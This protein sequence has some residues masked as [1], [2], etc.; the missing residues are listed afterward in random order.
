[1]KKMIRLNK[2][3]SERGIGSRRKCEQLIKEGKIAVDNRVVTSLSTKVD[4][5]THTISLKGKKIPPP[6]INRYFL[7]HK[8][9]GYITTMHD[10]SGRPTITQFFPAIKERLFPVGRL[11]CQS[12]GLLL[13][14]NDGALAYR[15]T[16]PKFKVPKVYMVKVQGII[17]RAACRTL[18]KGVYLEDGLVQVEKIKIVRYTKTNSWINVTITEG[19]NQI[20]RRIFRKLG[21]AV[22]KLTRIQFA[23]LRLDR[24]KPGEYRTLTPGEIKKLCEMVNLNNNETSYN[25]V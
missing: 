24:L 11:D 21:F 13:L 18:K 6:Q 22:L 9:R 5:R 3:L 4:A 7:L 15:L 1:M 8:P 12:Q 10:P 25:T 17:P 16:H 2:Y 14:T 20:I 23:F 19:K